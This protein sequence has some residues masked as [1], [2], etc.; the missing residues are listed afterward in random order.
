MVLVLM[1]VGEL[2]RLGTCIEVKSSFCLHSRS[3]CVRLLGLRTYH[4]RFAMGCDI[5]DVALLGIVLIKSLQHEGE[6]SFQI[7]CPFPA[8]GQ[9]L[10]SAGLFRSQNGH[11]P[12]L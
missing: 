8:F 11:L 1:L 6:Q 3:Q 9:A 10:A 2:F 12:E 4:T 7:S 5:D